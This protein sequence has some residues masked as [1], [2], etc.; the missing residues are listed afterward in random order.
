MFRIIENDLNKKY[1][2]L[3]TTDAEKSSKNFIAILPRCLIESN[4]LK[5]D[6]ILNENETYEG[7]IL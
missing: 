1:I 2:I 5:K 3:K 7:I 6:K 4:I